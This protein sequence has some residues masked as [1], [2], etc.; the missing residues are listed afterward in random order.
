M[1]SYIFLKFYLDICKISVEIKLDFYYFLN[2]GLKLV[3]LCLIES[4]NRSE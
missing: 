2:T 4:P 1:L 3:T